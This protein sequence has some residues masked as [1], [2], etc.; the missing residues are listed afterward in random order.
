MF[1]KSIV[2]HSSKSTTEIQMNK[3]YH[4]SSFLSIFM[5]LCISVTVI[6]A[7]LTVSVNGAH[8]SATDRI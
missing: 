6:C 2:R 8:S 3:E 4:F 1:Q 7:V 5:F